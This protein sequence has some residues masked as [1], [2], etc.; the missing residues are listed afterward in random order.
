MSFNWPRD[1]QTV[2]RGSVS[3]K[4][5]SNKREWIIDVTEITCT[6]ETSLYMWNKLESKVYVIYERQDYRDDK[7]VRGHQRLAGGMTW[8]H[9]GA[10]ELGYCWNCSRLGFGG[11]YAAVF[12]CQNVQNCNLKIN[13]TLNKLYLNEKMEKRI[14]L[15]VKFLISGIVIQIKFIRGKGKRDKVTWCNVNKE[16]IGQNRLRERI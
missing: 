4:T 7:Q 11:N 9:R 2:V 15:Q 14:T 12:T 10:G 13:L 6:C 16:L 3:G 8:W 1:K 5:R